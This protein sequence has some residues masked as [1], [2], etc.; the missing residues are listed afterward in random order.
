MF[1][2]FF[3]NI[4]H[5]RS[6]TPRS[7]ILVISHRSRFSKTKILLIL[8]YAFSTSA[9]IG[10]RGNAPLLQ[11]LYFAAISLSVVCSLVPYLFS[12]ILG[13]KEALKDKLIAPVIYAAVSL[14]FFLWVFIAMAKYAAPAII[15]YTTGAI[16]RFFV[17]RERKEKFPPVEFI[18][19]AIM[20]MG[21]LIIAYVIGKGYFQ[22]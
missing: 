3:Y 8:L 9:D 1:C 21:S 4:S 6:Q 22:F 20:L 13:I 18:F 11:N 5:A 10:A 15:I 14:T 12:S 7:F 19:Y 2:F 17:H 16:V